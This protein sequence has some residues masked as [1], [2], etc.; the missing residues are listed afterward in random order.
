MALIAI[1]NVWA[2]SVE[3]LE[4]SIKMIRNE[5]DYV[6]VLNQDVILAPNYIEILVNFLD[7]HSQV[8]SVSGKIFYWDFSVFFNF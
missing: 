1:Y 6:L 2:D 4:D 8:A 5:V 3:H 7:K